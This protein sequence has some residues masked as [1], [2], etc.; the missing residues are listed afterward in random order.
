MRQISRPI[1]LVVMLVASLVVLTAAP[2]RATAA[3][4]TITPATGLIDGQ[5]VHLVASGLATNSPAGVE[6]CVTG[7]LLAG[8][9]SGSFTSAQ[10]SGSGGFS[11]DFTVQTIL[12]TPDGT[13][14]CRTTDCVLGTNTTFD[15][16]GAAFTAI[17]FDP[18]GALLPPPVVHATPATNLIDH[19]TVTV[20]GTG[21]RPNG[22]AQV[23]QCTGG[24]TLA[25]DCRGLSMSG[26]PISPTGTFSATTS[27][28]TR[29]VTVGGTTV[30]CRSAVHACELVVGPFDAS[31]PALNGVVAAVSFDP[32]A[33]APPPAAIVVTPSTSLIDGQVVHITGS[34]YPVGAMVVLQ[35]CANTTTIGSCAGG[36]FATADSTGTFAA[37]VPLRARLWAGQLIDCRNA[38][39][40]CTMQAI[41]FEDFESQPRV[42]LTFTA[43][44][45]LL[46]PPTAKATPNSGLLD[47]DHVSLSGSNFVFTSGPLPVSSS[48]AT[49]TWPTR[50]GR[51]TT[52]RAKPSVLR[53]TTAPSS[54]VL[55]TECT[56]APISNSGGSCS[57]VNGLASVDTTGHLTGD[58][59]VWA[60]FTTFTGTKVDCRTAGVQCQLHVG[61][62]DPT[63]SATTDLS[64]DP[65]GALLPLPTLT[66]SPNA[67]LTD[68]TQMH[69][70][71]DGFAPNTSVVLQQCAARSV[72]APNFPC[73]QA[74]FEPQ[75]ATTD[76]AGHL[77]TVTTAYATL[78]YN[79]NFQP[80]GTFNSSTFDCTARA[81]LC[82]VMVLNFGPAGRWPTAGLSYG[83]ATTP[84]TILPA[85]VHPAKATA[86]VATTTHPEFTG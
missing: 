27:V 36:L 51:G 84:T 34:G 19:Q 53:P 31:V 16:T 21:F 73:D 30:D 65:T 82:Q 57:P 35:Q 69:V 59:Q 76:G 18:T 5:T 28:R 29:F 15:A 2:A 41:D 7:H 12:H 74:H 62:G 23:V 81:D 79:L 39:T 85:S 80:D 70:V 72:D 40:T 52:S 86:P 44:G 75:W 6:Q 46:P 68:G 4:L 50:L 3:S 71:G 42:P 63:S 26:G 20:D 1:S 9:D 83:S 8:C 11:L 48:T 10:T 22:F 47:G 43:D 54:L 33:A 58:V 49:A 64:F 24:A 60:T 37:D 61:W 77:D 67:E 55:V 13:F 45:P 66:V 17:A 38:A 78:K 14:D 25:S 56:N 32:L